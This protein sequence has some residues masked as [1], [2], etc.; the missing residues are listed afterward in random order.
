MALKNT[1]KISVG[2]QATLGVLSNYTENNR[3]K[4]TP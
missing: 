2:S 1:K 3:K 4:R